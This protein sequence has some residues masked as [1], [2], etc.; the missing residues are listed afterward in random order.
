[1]RKSGVYSFVSPCPVQAGI[2]L[3]WATSS[4]FVISSIA[5]KILVLSIRME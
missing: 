4:V 5:V 2:W 3:N 1:V